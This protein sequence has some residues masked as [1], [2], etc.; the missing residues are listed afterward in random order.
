MRWLADQM[1]DR[2]LNQ[3][4][5]WPDELSLRYPDAPPLRV[6]HGAPGDPFGF[7]QWNMEDGEI[8]PKLDGV[9]ESTVVGG[10]THLV[11]DRRVG[12]WWLLNPGAVGAPLDGIVDARYLLLDST[13]DGWDATWRRVPYDR[14]RLFA[15]FERERVVSRFGWIARLIVE[16]FRT[17]R[18][19]VGPFFNWQRAQ[20]P[21]EPITLNLVD[22]FL[23]E[24]DPWR[25][26]LEA[27]H[28]YCGTQETLEMA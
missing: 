4:A 20:C 11:L 8:L 23:N 9:E 24:V 15:A 25:Y 2:L 12:R 17:A 18:L 7:I 10:H 13:P 21:N 14:E 16:E 19:A 26:T 6:M 5:A 28:V 27:Y 22:Y 1:S 3:V